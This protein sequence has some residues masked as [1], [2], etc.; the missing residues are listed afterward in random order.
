MKKIILITVGIIACISSYS[1]TVQGVTSIAGGVQFVKQP[2]DTKTFG[3]NVSVGQF[4]LDGFLFGVHFGL[5]STKGSSGSPGLEDSKSSD[6][7]VGP[8]VRKYIF[9]ANEQFAF[10]ADGGVLIG[11]GSSTNP[12]SPKIKSGYTNIFIEPGFTYFFTQNWALDL[13]FTGFQFLRNDPNKDIDGNEDTT[14][15]LGLNSL[16]PSGFSIRYYFNNN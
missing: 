5:Q 15:L 2:S 11:F 14:I 12:P 10:F 8:F 13:H 3:A 16:S 9:S 1:Q 4:I 6:I 7:D